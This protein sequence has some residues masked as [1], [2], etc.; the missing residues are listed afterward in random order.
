MKRS[1]LNSMGLVGLL[2]I[3]SGAQ[4]AV[5][6]IDPNDVS[7][8]VQ[9]GNDT[10]NNVALNW[11]ASVDP[12]TQQTIYTL[13][14]DPIVLTSADGSTFTI[15]G[16]TFDPD[17][18]LLFSASATNNGNNPLV[19]SFSF[20]TPLV[21]ALNG[22]ISSHAELGVTLTDG[23]NDGAAVRPLIGQGFMLK[24]YDLYG[25]GDSVSKNVDVGT[26]Y[27]IFSS[28]GGTSYSAD[29]S[30]VCAQACVT[31]SSTLQFTLTGH[32]AVGLSGKVTQ[33][34]VPIPAAGVLLLSGLGLLSRATRRKLVTK[35]A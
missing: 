4:A 1:I 33:S 32:D 23:L 12:I 21:P 2:V 9:I 25:N 13:I 10:F 19:Y 15:G 6:T 8:N 29:S 35:L 3:T 18:L 26:A 16:A 27:S 17:P 24:S 31:M 5:A 11:T 30:L 34:P 20:N 28:T 22:N 7:M 14:G